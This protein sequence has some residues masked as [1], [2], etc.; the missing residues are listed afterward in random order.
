MHVVLVAKGLAA[1]GAVAGG[2]VVG[3]QHGVAS[4]PAQAAAVRYYTVQPGDTLA[5]IAGKFCGNPARYPS[6]AAASGISNPN[7]I[8]TGQHITISCGGG[9][10][11]APQSTRQSAPRR[12][13]TTAIS[14]SSYAAGSANIPGVGAIFSYA[15]LE[16][17]WISAG[18][19]SGAASV[20]ACIAEHES[21][22]R[23]DAISPTNDWGLWQIH[24]GGYAMFNPMA[25]A[26]TAVRMSGNGTN[27]SAWTTARSCGV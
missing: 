13:A 19:R 21:G 25:N 9:G 2:A 11:S 17:L 12:A 10:A 14:G 4:H 26:E 15:G 27:W 7:L 22:G 3:V 20:A 18:G 8:F 6:L 24:N 23:Q 1:A 5:K 16:R